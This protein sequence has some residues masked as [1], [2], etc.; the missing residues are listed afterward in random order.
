MVLDAALYGDLD[1][2][3]GVSWWRQGKYT[4]TD[5]GFQA[6]TAAADNTTD[7]NRVL[8]G[9]T[10]GIIW[11]LDSG[12]KDAGSVAKAK[13]TSHRVGY[14]SSQRAL[15]RWI[16]ASHLNAG[17]F[18]W[19]VSVY[20]DGVVARKVSATCNPH[21]SATDDRVFLGGNEVFDDTETFK[22]APERATGQLSYSVAARWFQ[23]EI[24]DTNEAPFELDA[25]EVEVNPLGRRRTP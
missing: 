13:L 24:S 11:E 15:V 16:G 2:P 5:Y 3:D 18:P 1:A 22:D 23:I 4:S 7:V 12:L 6:V 14:G 8:I 19:T 25:L 20:D 10:N 21:R 17:A 9:D